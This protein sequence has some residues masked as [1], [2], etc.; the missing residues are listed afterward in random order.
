MSGGEPKKG[1]MVSDHR[2]D[3]D[4]IAQRPTMWGGANPGGEQLL[5]TEDLA[6]QWYLLNNI[7][8]EKDGEGP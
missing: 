8:R 5:I 6:G 3:H 7:T 2:E 4:E 1:V